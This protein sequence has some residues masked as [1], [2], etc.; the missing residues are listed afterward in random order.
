MG[1]RSALLRYTVPRVFVVTGIGGRPA[2]LATERVVRLRGW[3]TALSPAEANMLVLCAP[4]HHGLDDVIGRLWGQLPCPRSR[5]HV[6]RPDEAE[7]QLDAA[8]AALTDLPHQLE[9]AATRPVVPAAEPDNHRSGHESH[10][11]HAG[12]DMGGMDMPGGL[13][14]ADR[15]EDRDGL[16]LD[17]L[18]VSL[19]PALP[20]WPAGLVVRL[21]L[22]GDVV[23]Q[24][25][26]AAPTYHAP[27]PPLAQYGP[28]ERLDSMQRLLAVAGWPAAAMTAR[29]LRDDLAAGASASDLRRE[30]GRW[31]RRVRRSRL[32]HWATDGVGVLGAEVPEQLRGD[33]TARWMRWLDDV[34]VAPASLARTAVDVLPR[35]LVGQEVAAARLIVASLDPDID[36]LAASREPEPAH[37]H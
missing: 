37:G 36:A 22:Q 21:T 26:V 2:R 12:H 15:G 30:Y 34:E 5:T 4:Q 35:L 11:G 20:D 32:L 13:A 24:A 6:S 1:L 7:A 23:Q 29:R 8:A 28:V 17:Q 27:A 19:G 14:M 18:H 33:A 9:Q 25:H 10:S 16:K 3:R 31:S